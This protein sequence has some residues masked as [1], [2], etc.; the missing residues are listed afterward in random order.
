MSLITFCILIGAIAFVL[1]FL[2]ILAPNS[3]KKL[4]ELS[5]KM[6]AKIDSLTFSYRIG[7]GVSLIIASAF[8]FFMAYYFTKRH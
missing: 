4:N 1:G 6:I 5:A 2:L 3:V 8:M 7:F